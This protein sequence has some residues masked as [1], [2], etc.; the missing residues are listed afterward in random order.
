MGATMPETFIQIGDHSEKAKKF[1]ADY[2]KKYGVERIPSA[3]SAAQ[4][5]DSLY[6]ITAAIAQAGSTDGPK[7]KAA[8]EDLTQPYDGVIASFKKPFSATD[9]EAIHA[10]EV[11]MGVVHGGEVHPP[12]K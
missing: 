5:Y 1:I 7:I 3:V 10:A 4:G 2:Q 6:L 11:V 12:E 9:H 8:L